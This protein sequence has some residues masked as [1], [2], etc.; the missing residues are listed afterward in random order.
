MANVPHF[1]TLGMFIID[2][3]SFTDENEN[4]LPTGKTIPAQGS[5]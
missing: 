5:S 4:G 3:F 1:V 2:E